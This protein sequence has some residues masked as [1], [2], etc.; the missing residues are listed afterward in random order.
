MSSVKRTSFAND[1]DGP[2]AGIQRSNSAVGRAFKSVSLKKSDATARR[3]SMSVENQTYVPPKSRTSSIFSAVTYAMAGRL[4]DLV[5]WTYDASAFKVIAFFVVTYLVNIFVWALVLDSIDLATGG[6]CIHEDPEKVNRLSTRF[7]Y[8]FELSWAT[9]TTVGY[10][11]ISPQ[12]DETGCYA[13]RFACAMVAFI[14][15]LYASVSRLR[16]CC[17]C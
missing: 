16:C 7:E 6:Y 1:A 10:G 12:G 13:V 9:F 11:T 2:D 14:G 15:V 5:L 17:N 3:I 8:V 4:T